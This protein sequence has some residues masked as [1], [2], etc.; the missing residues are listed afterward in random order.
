MIID[1]SGHTCISCYTLCITVWK[2]VKSRSR[3][4]ISCMAKKRWI[5][6]GGQFCCHW[7]HGC[8]FALW[9]ISA[10][11]AVLAR[12]PNEGL[13]AVAS[14][15]SFLHVIT[16]T[17]IAAWCLKSTRTHWKGRTRKCNPTECIQK[18]LCFFAAFWD[19]GLI[20]KKQ[21]PKWKFMRRKWMKIESSLEH[22]QPDYSIRYMF[23]YN[24][25]YIFFNI[26]YL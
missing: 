18:R 25:Y 11:R 22:P 12:C 23:Y 15:W 8:T 16:C 13:S 26:L 3:G 14:S 24:T 17:M 5:G 7:H 4:R 10:R 21:R 19:R 2:C 20:T 9:P 1:T 6:W